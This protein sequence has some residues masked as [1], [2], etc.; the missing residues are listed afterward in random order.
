V[1]RSNHAVP[2][3]DIKVGCS[4]KNASSD[5]KP[6][7]SQAHLVCFYQHSTRFF[8]VLDDALIPSLLCLR[9]GTANFL[10]LRSDLVRF[11][12]DRACADTTIGRGPDCLLLKRT[13]VLRYAHDA[14]R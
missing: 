14:L 5:I 8:A 4:F 13:A 7:R 1:Y 6:L 12:A 10:R 3:S 2:G 11:V 9:A